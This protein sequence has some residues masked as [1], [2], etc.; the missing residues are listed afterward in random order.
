MP[1]TPPPDTLHLELSQAA[2]VSL[3][4]PITAIVTSAVAG[5]SAAKL[6]EIGW[7]VGRVRKAAQTMAF[8][9]PSACLLA[10][11]GTDD[12]MTTVALISVA[13]GLNSFSLAGLYCNHQDLSPRY[14]SILLGM[15]NT[16]ASIPGVIGVAAAGI[17]L[18]QT[19]SW[20][21]SL[22]VPSI[23]CFVMGT[24][25][26]TLFG[27]AQ[28]VDFD[29]AEP[30]R[31]FEFERKLVDRFPALGTWL[32]RP[33]TVRASP[34]L[35]RRDARDDGDE[36]VRCRAPACHAQPAFAATGSLAAL[37]AGRTSWGAQGRGRDADALSL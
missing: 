35:H 28:G 3:I 26:F 33:F 1:A 31:P 27:S 5:S 23:A 34:G 22:F 24:A 29:D 36:S 16:V 19:H 9:G 12:P 30:N 2:Q 32:A 21:L 14:A 8:M 25:A 37:S 13:I 6:L 15:T 4:P 7:P 18:D 17:I 11:L 20:E 10:S